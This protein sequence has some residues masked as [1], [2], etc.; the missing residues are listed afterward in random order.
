MEEEGSETQ[1][2]TSADIPAE[3]RIS[4]AW[5]DFSDKS[6]EETQKGKVAYKRAVPRASARYALNPGLFEDWNTSEPGFIPYLKKKTDRT[7]SDAS[8]VPSLAG[9]NTIDTVE[10][11]WIDY[12]Q[13]GVTNNLPSIQETP[14]QD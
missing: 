10:P 13:N 12:E 5:L 7:G 4:E 3:H 8:S 11:A 6:T 9:V 14:P 2:K 1:V